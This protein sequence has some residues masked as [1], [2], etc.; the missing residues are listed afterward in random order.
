M[1]VAGLAQQVV[2]GIAGRARGSVAVALG[3][4][5]GHSYC[6]HPT[7]VVATG[8]YAMVDSKYAAPTL[9]RIG[10][11]TN[12]LNVFCRHSLVFSNVPGPPSHWRLAGQTAVGVQ[13]FYGN[14]LPQ[15]GFLSYAGQI[16][17]NMVVDPEALPNADWLAGLYA[18]ALLDLADQLEVE[19]PAEDSSVGQ[20]AAFVRI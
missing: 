11:P 20:A 18:Q 1:C 10:G 5:A 2:L 15:V 3:T 13:M 16:F 19:Q 17:G 14:L 4:L 7:Q 8:V 6:D 12:G 9:A